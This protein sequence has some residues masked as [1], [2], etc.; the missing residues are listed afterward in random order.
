MYDE[1]T[2]FLMAPD[3]AQSVVGRANGDGLSTDHATEG[4]RHVAELARSRRV[5]LIEQD[6]IAA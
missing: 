3:G 1:P 5:G 2:D 6:I 4:P